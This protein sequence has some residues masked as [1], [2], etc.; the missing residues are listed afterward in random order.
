[1]SK[2]VI[3]RIKVCPRLGVNFTFGIS[4]QLPLFATDV[5]LAVGVHCYDALLQHSYI[6]S[7]YPHLYYYIWEDLVKGQLK[8]TRVCMKRLVNEEKE[9]FQ[10][11]S[12]IK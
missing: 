8:S 5:N 11:R 1:M 10:D 12:R 3:V 2:N 4:C 9:I 6:H 7:I